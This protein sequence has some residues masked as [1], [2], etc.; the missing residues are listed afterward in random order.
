MKIYV[1]P[2]SRK[3]SPTNSMEYEIILQRDDWNDYSYI[4]KYHLYLTKKL[5]GSDEIEYVGAVKIIKK[6]QVADY[7]YMVELGDLSPLST[8]YCSVGQSLDYYTRL[9]KLN[10]E[11]RH[12]ILM[13]LRD[14]N[15]FDYELEGF[16]NE[17]VWAFSVMRDLKDDDD[18]FLLP[19]YILEHNFSSIPSID[20][21]F[22][23]S[24]ER[25][26]NSLKLDFDSEQYGFFKYQKLP[27]RM[28]VIVGR[29]GTG[30][31]TTLAR[32]SKVAY[33]STQD[34]KNEIIS[35][36]GK[37]YPE[38]LGFPKIINLSYSAFD[39]FQ[40]P[41]VTFKEKV[42]LKNDIAKGKGRYIYCGVRDVCAE[43]ELELQK[44]D[45]T[46]IEDI[47]ISSERQERTI[48]KPL[49]ILSKEFNDA[50]IKIQQDDSKK[51]TLHSVLSKLKEEASISTIVDD[52][53][54]DDFSENPAAYFYNLST[55][56]KFVLHSMLHIILYAEK[57]C[58]VF[59]DE[60]ETHLHPPLLAV[61]MSAL[62]IILNKVDAFAIVATHSPVVVQETLSKNVNVITRSGNLIDFQM[63]E[64]ETFGENI[65]SITSAVFSLTSQVTD[66]HDELDKLIQAYKPHDNAIEFIENLFDQGLS[67]QA[68]SYI[69]SKLAVK[70]E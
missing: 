48:L 2:H 17:S 13:S 57:R 7:S 65:G 33:S 40:I 50:Y 53:L 46:D 29:N 35:G 55:G 21:K 10:N 39:S 19:K 69:L 38:G 20:V 24:H 32:L 64:I 54:E 15:L 63:P 42:Q 43:L 49:E 28:A 8:E 56:H 16:K 25:M 52:M 37:I 68:R 61:L 60:P 62:R 22:E 34:R 27:C 5:T 45:N 30:K 44:Y 12:A 11:V 9:S 1:T 4:T 18:I 31:S 47:Y 59:F 14:I 67:I 41:G 70:E 66:Y 36:I 3:D 51:L 58:F 6:G 23:F 26:L